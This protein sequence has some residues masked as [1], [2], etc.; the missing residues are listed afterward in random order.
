MNLTNAVF[1]TLEK[2]RELRLKLSLALNIREASV[3]RS[4]RARSDVFTKMAAVR[5]IIEHTGLS[6]SEIFE[7]SK[8]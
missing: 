3:D 4:I 5:V 2:D 7:S 1:E 8:A 6:E